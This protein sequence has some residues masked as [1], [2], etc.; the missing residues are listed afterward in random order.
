M[1]RLIV[2]FA[3][4]FV[5]ALGGAWMADRPGTMVLEWENYRVETSVMIASVVL[6]GIIVAFV[7][8]WA[9]L[10]RIIDSPG[11]LKRFFGGRRRERG[12]KALTQGL[13]AV[14]SGDSRLAGK[15][16]KE[17]QKLLRNEPAT[18]LLTAQ[19][20][21]LAGQGEAARDS[22][23]DMLDHNATKLLGLHGL[24]VEA[25]REGE[26]AAACHYAEQ[27]SELAPSLPWAGK[28]VFEFQS[29]GRDWEAALSTLERNAHNKL[30]DKKAARRLRAVL[31][32]ARALELEDSEPDRARTLAREAHGLA[33]DLVPAA[34]VA[35]RL[36]SRAGDFGRA[37]KIL[38]ATWKKGPHPEIAEA[39]THIRPGDSARDR[40][41]R[42]ETLSKMRAYHPEGAL[43][44]A[45]VAIDVHDW[46]LARDTLA[47]VLRSAPTQRA[48]LM[49]A[50]VE[51]GE[52]GD[53]GRVREWLAKA[54]RAPRDPV[55]IADGVASEH[56]APISPTTG[57]LDAFEWKVP[58]SGLTAPDGETIDEELLAPR[59]PIT[60][61]A[62]ATAAAPEAAKEIEIVEEMPVEAAKVEEIETEEETAPS[63]EAETVEAIKADN[64]E[65]PELPGDG[66]ALE[67]ANDDTDKPV[68]ALVAGAAEDA[69]EPVS[70]S[71][72]T[73]AAEKPAV[74]DKDDED[75]GPQLVT[76]PLGH[77]PDDPGP[78]EKDED[79]E[80]ARFKLF[81]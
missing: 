25:R 4:L 9:V 53:Q 42:I 77:A 30:V 58:V 65:K 52:H 81:S 40:L 64:D 45:Q 80:K 27:A 57:R 51:E 32:T 13:I 55:W 21:Q 76:F 38:E 10:R 73:T 26:M 47:K 72:E 50:D 43:A 11:A 70:D 61:P 46:T 36:F 59:A 66:E 20:A 49:M 44:L 75:N 54:V 5:V 6:I 37:A 34:V 3:V 23:T 8:L 68:S 1:I 19:A 41:Q 16:A 18:K 33:P 2:F 35:G 17:A 22:F 28:A 78:D 14:G 39:Y 31:L 67:P 24:Y 62:A 15:L 63:S 60:A 69:A 56:W 29:A 71:A 48:C 79:D 12:Y 74:S 7:L